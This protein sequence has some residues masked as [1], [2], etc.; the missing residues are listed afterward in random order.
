[1][2]S[3]EQR[4]AE[5]AKGTKFT[6][7]GEGTSSGQDTLTCCQAPGEALPLPRRRRWHQRHASASRGTAG[8]E[9]AKGWRRLKP[10]LPALCHLHTHVTGRTDRPRVSV[11]TWALPKRDLLKPPRG[12]AERIGCLRELSP[13]RGCGIS[14]LRDTPR[15][16]CQDLLSG[17]P[18]ELGTGRFPLH[19][20]ASGGHPV[21]SHPPIPGH[22][23]GQGK[24]QEPSAEPVGQTFL[25]RWMFHEPCGSSRVFHWALP[26][27]SLCPTPTSAAPWGLHTPERRCFTAFPFAGYFQCKQQP[28]AKI[29]AVTG[30]RS[31]LSRFLTLLEGSS[32][33]PPRQPSSPA[34]RRIR[35]ALFALDPPSQP[36][37][38][39]LDAFCSGCGEGSPPAGAAAVHVAF[40]LA[41]LRLPVQS[42]RFSPLRSSYAFA[43][44]N[45]HLTALPACDMP[46]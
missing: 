2:V 10:T 27:V 46:T 36:A 15:D 32:P 45:S 14:P 28:L 38:S 33:P 31:L 40:V 22:G 1:M 30:S 12:T 26:P 18:G 43:L 5:Q 34:R 24:G 13:R 29:L 19:P 9:G 3:A 16:R 41:L 44:G 23:P 4:W 8:R 11:R 42:G 17:S 25:S 35:F 39:L 20:P 37:P 6:T 7:A 21:R